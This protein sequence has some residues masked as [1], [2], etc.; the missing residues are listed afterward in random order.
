MSLHHKLLVFWGILG[1]S[2]VGYPAFS[3]ELSKLRQPTNA[4]FGVPL[5]QGLDLVHSAEP[6][7]KG[8]FRMRFLN[9]LH[10]VLLPEVGT[11]SSYT[12]HYGL[13]YGFGDGLDLGFGVP[14]LVDSAGG[15]NKFGTGDPVL[16]V[17]WARNKKVAAPSH[18]AFLL[19]IGLPLGFKEKR[20]L[21]QFDG[22][23]RSFSNESVDFGLQY[24]M[25]FQADYGALY[26]NGGLFRSGN[27]DVL[28]QLV[29]G[30]GLDLGRQRKRF[31]LNLE[32]QARVAYTEETRASGILKLGARLHLT[33]GIELELNREF[34]FWDHPTKQIFTFGLRFH[35][36]LTG[37]RHWEPRYTLYE[38]PPRPKRAY[39]PEKILRLALLDFAGFEQYHAGQR[40]VE[41]IKTR[42]APH[43]SIEVVDLRR[44][45]NVPTKGNISGQQA[46]ELGRKIGIDVFI[47]GTV[48]DFDLKRFA[49][50]KL[51][52]IVEVPEAEVAIALR[53]RVQL[54]GGAKELERYD[55]EAVGKGHMV[56]RPRL[57]PSDKMDITATHNA[58]ALERIQE[59]ALDNLV[60]NLLATMATRFAWIP[61]DFAP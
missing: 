4:A 55:D 8:R 41:K 1:L 38:P 3:Q 35:G 61:P 26:L 14:F 25:D 59:Q 15:L 6:L 2:L 44:Y 30:I 7:G 34:G 48:D 53:Y 36:Y 39:A 57:L 20:G 29:Y 23:I 10:S 13:G 37:N 49:G 50:K 40:L 18:S 24:I 42:L 22:G 54:L 46:I 12:G 17:K 32:Y 27:P 31:N 60:D 52:Y 16:S 33:K 28:S 47:S 21:D 5:G 9:R 58:L 43:D 11:G 45:A 51:P 56:Q 19:Q